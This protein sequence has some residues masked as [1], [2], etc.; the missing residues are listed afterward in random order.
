MKKDEKEVIEEK[1]KEANEGV[2]ETFDP[3]EEAESADD[4]QFKG[5][6]PDEE[7]K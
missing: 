3:P 2:G 1:A 4:N 6:E 5:F 7:V